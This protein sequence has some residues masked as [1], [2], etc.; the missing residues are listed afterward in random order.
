MERGVLPGERGPDGTIIGGPLESKGDPLV[1]PLSLV[2]PPGDQEGGTP[3][4]PATETNHLEVK[5]KE[6]SKTGKTVVN[7]NLY[8]HITPLSNVITIIKHI[9]LYKNEMN[10]IGSGVARVTTT[11]LLKNIKPKIIFTN[12]FQ[13]KTN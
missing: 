13:N 7:Y 9:K 1:P 3:V 2:V 6:D 10:Q 11:N 4:H 5:E 8:G 12:H